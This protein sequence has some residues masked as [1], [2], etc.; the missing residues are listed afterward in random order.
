L[1]PV[2][3]IV[4]AASGSDANAKQYANR[5]REMSLY[6]FIVNSG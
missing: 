3:A 5:R 6:D 2:I 1:P 4:C